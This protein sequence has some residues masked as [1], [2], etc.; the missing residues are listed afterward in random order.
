MD[1]DD[2]RRLKA[3][4]GSIVYLPAASARLSMNPIT[5]MVSPR[6][7]GALD[8]GWPRNVA[9]NELNGR[10]NEEGEVPDE[11]HGNDA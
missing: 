4:A 3:P 5:L 2:I 9:R 8:T 1:R 6:S 11:S 7:G 10:V